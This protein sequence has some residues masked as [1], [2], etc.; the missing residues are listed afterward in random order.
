M[1]KVAVQAKSTA[2]TPL[3]ASTSPPRPGPRKKL[4]PSIVLAVALQAVSCSGVSANAG[5]IEASAGRNGAPTTEIA[6]ART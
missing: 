6:T 3:A 5:V 1:R 2:W 4:A